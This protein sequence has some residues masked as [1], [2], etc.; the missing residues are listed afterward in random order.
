MLP[1]TFVNKADYDL[2]SSDCTVDLV[3]LDKLAPGS[4]V[5][6]NVRHP[7]G[8]QDH[9]QLKHTLSPMQLEWLQ[10]GSALNYIANQA[11]A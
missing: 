10:A 1:L 3:G 7:D 8:S 9:V 2:V 6:L 5:V 11:K 4:E